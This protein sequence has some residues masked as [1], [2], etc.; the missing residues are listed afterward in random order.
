[1]ARILIN[2]PARAKRGEVIEIKTLI[3]HPME[4]GYRLGATGAAIPRDIINRFICTYNGEEMFRADSVPAIAANPFITFF[5]R[6]D[7]E[8]RARL[9]L[10]RR[11]RPDADRVETNHGRMKALVVGGASTAAAAAAAAEIAPADRRSGYDFAGPRNPGDAGRRHGQSRDAGGA[12]R[13]GIVGDQGRSRRPVVRRL[14]RRRANQHEGRGGA[15]SGLRR[16]RSA[17][18][19]ISKSGSTAAAASTRVRRHSPGKA[20]ICSR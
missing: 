15:L 10:D 16:R 11:P 6:R 1:M 7:R 14:P 4:T 18:R 5:T 19:S 9:Q 2:V 12:A 3:A 13:R 20:T 8:R 17:G